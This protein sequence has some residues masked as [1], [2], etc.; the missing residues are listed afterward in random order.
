MKVQPF[1][2]ERYLARYEFSVPYL[3]CCSDCEPLPMQELLSMADE[4]SL[5][6]WHNLSLGYTDSQ[7]HPL[8]RAEIAKLYEGIQPGQVLVLC[9]EEGIFIAMNVLLNQ[10]DHII[11]TFPGYQSL[12]EI[13]HSLGCSVT[14]W[15]PQEENGWAFDM[16]FLEKAIR[17][18]TKMIVVNFPHNPTGALPGK[19]N[20]EKIAN[21]AKENHIYLFSDE[22]YRFLE[23]DAAYRLPAGAE[24][25]EQGISLFGMSKTF[26]LAGLRLGW[27]V[28]RDPD[29]M[30]KLIAFKDYTTICSSAPGEIL[31]LLALRVKD[32]IIGRNLEIIKSNLELLDRFFAGRPGLFSWNKPNAGSI[33]LPRLLTKEKTSQFC[34]EIIEKRGVVLLPS[35]VYDY[36]ENHFRIGFG[37]RDMPEALNLI[38]TV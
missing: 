38:E 31:A 28:T 22:M 8:L 25:Y 2:L 26:A 37:R 16:T 33:A 34:H 35:S 4:E 17:K 15:E 7:G 19:E 18:N 6:L 24:I 36:G 30:K 9:P 12:Y 10:G 1:K 29:L 11:V 32:R 3:M 13:A 27:L 21:I 5:S 20:F 23:Y 14:R